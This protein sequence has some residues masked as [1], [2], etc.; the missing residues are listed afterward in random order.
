MRRC[1]PLQFPVDCNCIQNLPHPPLSS[2]AM[3]F[4]LPYASCILSAMI[5]S[6]RLSRGHKIRGRGGE[7]RRRPARAETLGPLN[8]TCFMKAFEFSFPLSWFKPLL[9]RPGCERVR[10]IIY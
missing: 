1:S 8:C 6:C 5:C 4:P 3:Q 2:M 9:W 7:G 10:A